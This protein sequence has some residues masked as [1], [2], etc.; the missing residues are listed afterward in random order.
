MKKQR[1]HFADKGLY[2]QN[3]GFSSSHVQM[4]ELDHKEAECR[5]ID[6]FELWGWRRLLRVPWMAR[7]SHQ[8][9]LNE[10]NPEYYLEG[11][12]LKLKL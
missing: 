7:R 4:S 6:V 8:S 9:I 3:Y 1:R 11:L 2:S 10:I 12:M 5:R